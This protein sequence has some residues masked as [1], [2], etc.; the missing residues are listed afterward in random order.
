M[1]PAGRAGTSWQW[2]TAATAARATD[3]DGDD[4]PQAAFRLDL[5]RARGKTLLAPTPRA[6]Q[7]AGPP[8]APEHDYQSKRYGMNP[9]QSVAEIRRDVERSILGCYGL[10]PVFASHAAAGTSLRESWRI[11]V[12]LFVA[13]VAEL[14]QAQLRE[15]L[16]EPRLTLGMDRCQA[17]DISTLARAVGSLATASIPVEAAVQRVFGDAP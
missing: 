5:A 8:A 17:A 13:P 6:G 16:D 4:D 10:P 15:A 12:A 9:P 1:R 2:S 11:A 3:A 14:V 7:G